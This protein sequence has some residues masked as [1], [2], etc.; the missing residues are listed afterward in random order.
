MTD[1]ED[2]LTRMITALKQPVD[3][4]PD[5]TAR[6]MAEV[7]Q[8]PTP[9]SDQA[10]TPR[11]DWWRRRW[12]V[13]FGPL[14]ALAT[15]AGIAAIGFAGQ[16]VGRRAGVASVEESATVAPAP[17]LTQFVLIAKDAKAVSLVGDFNDWS[18][19]ATPLTRS[20]GNGV[21]WV[22]VP[23][24]P[25]RYRFAYVVDG[26][27]WRPDPE[28]PAAEDEFGRPNSVLTIGGS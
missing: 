26:T 20:D 8:V 24:E 10:A 2:A 14:G 13:R 22:T 9:A 18:L 21:W 3:I 1:Q 11:R 25:G 5:V 7:R 17:G 4:G 19:S 16:R 27:V 28:A 6:V 12:T 15:A 23:L